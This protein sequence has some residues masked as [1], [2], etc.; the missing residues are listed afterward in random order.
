MPGQQ[1]APTRTNL[2]RLKAELAFARSGY[3]LLEQ[4]REILVL[5]LKRFTARA[6]EAQRKVDQHLAAAYAALREAQFATGFPGGASASNAVNVEP[7]MNL[8][9]RRVMGVSLP[10]V[11]LTLRDNPPY[12][13]PSGTSVWTDE[14][15][16]RFKDALG[17]IAVL[18]ECRISVIRLARAREILKDH[19]AAS[20]RSNGYSFPTTKTACTMWKAR[21]RKRT[22]KLSLSSS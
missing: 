16:Q 9:E 1:I 20:T 12:Y 11:E 22:A 7:V 2:L 4:K 14:A 17:S 19:C 3:E 21:S 13:G 18:A 15:V 8:R 10:A 6:I 5:E